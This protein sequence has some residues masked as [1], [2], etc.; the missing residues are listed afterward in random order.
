MLELALL[1]QDCSVNWDALSQYTL[2]A[3]VNLLANRHTNMGHAPGHLD[4]YHT[5][6]F[7]T[8]GT[9]IDR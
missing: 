7:H 8:C 9:A 1:Q 5:T 3:N 2:S 6:F 4:R